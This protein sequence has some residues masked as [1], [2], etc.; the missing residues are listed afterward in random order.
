MTR[1]RLPM[2]KALAR[3][4]AVRRWLACSR[5]GLVITSLAVQ[6]RRSYCLQMLS[7]AR[8]PFQVV[9]EVVAR[10]HALLPPGWDWSGVGGRPGAPEEARERAELQRSYYALLAA[11]AS[12]GVLLQSLQVAAMLLSLAKMQL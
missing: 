8:W 9:P 12:S 6:S 3:R 10:V 5:K 2:W 1:K 7:F 11:L 4:G